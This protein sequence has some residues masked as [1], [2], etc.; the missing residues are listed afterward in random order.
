[1]KVTFLGTG[2]SQG[3][4]VIACQCDVCRH[5]SRFDKRLRSSV[6]IEVSGRVFVIDSGPDFRQQML[7]E[8]VV[9]LD[10][11]FITH[12][13]KDHIGGMDDVRSYNWILKRPMDV[14][15]SETTQTIIRSDFFYAFDEYGY[16][17]APAIELHTVNYE[18]FDAHGVIV[19]PLQ[20]LH[21]N[22]PVLG[23]RIGDFAYI[24]DMNYL[25]ASTLAKLTDCKVI[26]MN[27]LRK[28]K[29][30]SHF[31]LEEAVHILE[32]LRPEKAYLTHISHQMGFH[33]E[34]E[35]ALPGFI[36]LAYDG[37]KIEL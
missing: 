36:R 22:M 15:A 4:P 34:V 5:G 1:M 3:V 32:F 35:K 9:R 24:T 30:V 19:Q 17:G 6:M 11:L 18:P 8:D 7:R 14:Y 13:H 26:V 10:G 16:P 31:N 21:F 33:N 28:K 23:F 12:H 2:T 25:P 20:G 27:A 29:H 37:L